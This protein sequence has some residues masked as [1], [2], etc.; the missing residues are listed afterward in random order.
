[1]KSQL[2]KMKAVNEGKTARGYRLKPE[3]HSLIVKIQKH[4]NSDQD[5]AIALACSMFFNELSKNKDHK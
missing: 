1:M 3:T 5:K 4:L 2:K